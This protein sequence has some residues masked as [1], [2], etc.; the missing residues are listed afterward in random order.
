MVATTTEYT[1][2][3][4]FIPLHSNLQQAKNPIDCEL[5][6]GEVALMS[7]QLSEP[8]PLWRDE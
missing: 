7:F 8:E 4:L 6:E 1:F 2:Y 3:I 5:F